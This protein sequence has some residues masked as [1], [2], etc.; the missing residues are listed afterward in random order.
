MSYMPSKDY[1]HYTGE[2]CPLQRNLQFKNDAERC[3]IIRACRSWSSSC[4]LQCKV[5]STD[6]LRCS[7]FTLLL[8]EVGEVIALVHVICMFMLLVFQLVNCAPMTFLCQ[9]KLLQHAS[10][11]FFLLFF[12]S[13]QLVYWNIKWPV[14]NASWADSGRSH[15]HYVVWHKCDRMPLLLSIHG[16]WQ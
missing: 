3:G 9:E 8:Q 2:K 7:P 11:R 5:C 1:K 15:K 16:H 13:I 10:V 4:H 14:L 6:Y 12:K